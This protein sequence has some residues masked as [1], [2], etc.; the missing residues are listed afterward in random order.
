[1]L[2]IEA[3]DD[4]FDHDALLWTAFHGQIIAAIK[5]VFVNGLRPCQSV[6]TD[7]KLYSFKYC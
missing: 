1:M 7:G 2:L 5:V 6:R 3:S 4:D